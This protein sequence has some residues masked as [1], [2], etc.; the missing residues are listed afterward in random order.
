MKAWE[1]TDPAM[2]AGFLLQ[3]VREEKVLHISR[4]KYNFAHPTYPR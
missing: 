4:G 1:A 3:L 2:A